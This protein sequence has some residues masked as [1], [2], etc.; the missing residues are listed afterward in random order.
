MEKFLLLLFFI[1]KILFIV[2]APIALYVF[3]DKYI[4]KY[5]G[6]IEIFGLI[7]F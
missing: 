7:V 5:I 6:L 1:I 4:S 2:V 3:R